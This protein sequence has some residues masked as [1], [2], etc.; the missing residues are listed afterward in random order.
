MAV[1]GEDVKAKDI[2]T[3]AMTLLEERGWTKY[4]PVDTRG[5]FCLMGAMG[6]VCRD[7]RRYPSITD[8]ADDAADVLAGSIMDDH[9]ISIPPMPSSWD[10][11][12][13]FNDDRATTFQDV[14]RILADAIARA[15]QGNDGE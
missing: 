11:V 13:R 12:I 8:A 4:E 7:N 2:L 10:A 5:R 1:G 9:T 3:Q 15:E 6:R 14:R